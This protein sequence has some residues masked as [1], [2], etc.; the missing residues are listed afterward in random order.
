MLP[1]GGTRTSLADV[2]TAVTRRPPIANY[3]WGGAGTGFDVCGSAGK[4]E[5]ASPL[6]W[7]GI[8]ASA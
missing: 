5:M 6:T 7:I 2:A 8:A 3:T 4:I 1:S